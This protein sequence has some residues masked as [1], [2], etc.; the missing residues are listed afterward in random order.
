MRSFSSVACRA[1]P[2]PHQAMPQWATMA[3]KSATNPDKWWPDSF[4]P[5]TARCHSASVTNSSAEPSEARRALFTSRFVSI[6]YD[7]LLQESTHRTSLLPGLID[8]Y[9]SP[10]ECATNLDYFDLQRQGCAQGGRCSHVTCSL[11][12]LC[13]CT[14]AAELPGVS[15]CAHFIHNKTV[16]GPVWAKEAINKSWYYAQEMS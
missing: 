4:T 13:P 8:K 10:I 11:P 1:G 12:A 15:N 2:L 16:L 14:A 5:E 9:L 7:Y 6:I 3:H